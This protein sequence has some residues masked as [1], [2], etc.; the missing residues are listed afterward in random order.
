MILRRAQPDDAPA[1][2]R[3]HVDSFRA[4][5]RDLT[6][7]AHLE[8]FSYALREERFREALIAGT[9]EDYLACVEANQEPVAILTIG[10]ARD[11]D[12]EPGT[13]EIWGI[14]IA[15]DYWRQ[16]IGTWLVREAEQ[17]L[18]ARGCASAVLWVLAGNHRARRFYEA[19]G[20][21]ADGASH[22][23]QW[24]TPLKAV[25]YRKPLSSAG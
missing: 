6:T 9:E 16:G 25:R 2:A 11:A 10:M 23:I 15:P 21:V 24:D 13:G 3:V 19:A 17:M 22:V 1:L 14:Y 4:A 20:Y 5:Y 8:R 12:L 18:V 7:P